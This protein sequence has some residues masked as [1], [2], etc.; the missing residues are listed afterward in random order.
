MEEVYN[1]EIWKQLSKNNKFNGKFDEIFK[2]CRFYAG[3]NDVNI[4]IQ[5]NRLILSYKTPI[6]ERELNCE[7]ITQAQYEIF[8][9][10][11]NN[12]VINEKS[13][14]MRSNYGY[15][16]E[17][18]DGGVIDIHYSCEVYDQ[19]GIELAYQGFNDSYTLT[20]ETFDKFKI[21]FLSFL[22]EIFKNDLNESFDCEEYPK[23]NIFGENPSFSRQVRRKDNLGI[24]IR[25]NCHYDQNGIIKDS[26]EEYFFNTFLSKKTTVRPEMI[27]VIR[28]YPF[29]IVDQDHNIHFNQIYTKTGITSKNYQ[30]VAR[31]RF[32][33]E[34]IFEKERNS[35]Y[36]SQDVLDK[37]DLMI[38]KLKKTTGIQRTR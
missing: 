2:K 34:L 16:F 13:G 11:K 29:A 22:D 4:K 37:Y 25:S 30:E 7:K 15:N 21:D 23:P 18:S 26:K 12:L 1:S 14:T 32:L 9:D 20:K 6:E 28:E 33:K 19:F 10:N 3:N 31:E 17:I 27:S 38:E 24:V 5:N 35:K 36:A 8:I